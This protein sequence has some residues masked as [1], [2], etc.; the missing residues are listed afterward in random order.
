MC[1]THTGRIAA[2]AMSAMSIVTPRISQM[3][4]KA[5][6]RIRDNDAAAIVSAGQILDSPGTPHTASATST[7]AAMVVT[8]RTSATCRRADSGT[9]HEDVKENSGTSRAR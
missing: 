7:N 4:Q 3:F 9:S 5:T 6:S 2:I 8:I 1:C